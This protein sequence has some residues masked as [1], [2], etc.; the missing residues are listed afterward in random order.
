[1]N[2]TAPVVDH[3]ILVLD[4]EQS[5]VNAI[6]RELS[7]PPLG[8]YRYA[9][10]VFTDPKA[11]LARAKEKEFEVVLTDYRMPEMDGLEFL[12]A[13]AT[14]QP[15]SVRIVLSGQTDFD[16]LVRMVNE[17]HIYR[18]I[19][20]PW[21][22]NF[23]KSSIF[24]AI[25]FREANIEN[26]RLAEM[27]SQNG[28]GLPA[29][30]STSTDQILVV[31]RSVNVADAVASSLA[32]YDQL[33]EVFREVQVEIHGHATDL[34][35]GTINVQIADSPSHAMELANDH[36]FSC[37]IADYRMPGMDG[38]EFLARFIDKQPDCACLILSAV[39]DME[40]LITTLD[41]A[42]INA[43]LTKPWVDYDLNVAVA[44]ALTQRRLQLENR[45]FARMCQE[46]NLGTVG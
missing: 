25:R 22:I 36:T 13:F 12:K 10:E 6:R 43:F 3:A 23:L 4:D 40:S 7:T 34:K 18:F 11:A 26:R 42:H 44:Q 29:G 8:R 24:Q 45:E 37:I 19:P 16:S 35:P 21:N 46:R 1:M 28:I 5:I 33:N 31:D 39:V 32:K 41:L 30:F 2:T 9:V 38:A 15:E 20:K 14:L 17:T 27:L